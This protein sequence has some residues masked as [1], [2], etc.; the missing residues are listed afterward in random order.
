MDDAGA[1]K[2]PSVLTIDRAAFLLLRVKRAFKKKRQQ[3]KEKHAAAAA[4]AAADAL[5]SCRRAPPPLL[6]SRT[7]PA[8]VVPGL[9]ILHA[10]I[11]PARNDLTQSQMLCRGVS[12]H[13]VCGL[14]AQAPRISFTS[15]EEAE[16]HELRRKS[17]S[18]RLGSSPRSSI[19]SE[20]R[21]DGIVLRV[22]T[23]RG[24]VSSTGSSRLA[25]LLAHG[26]R[27]APEDVAMDAPR[28]LSWE[29]RESFG[30]LPRSASIDSMVEA[31]I[32]ARH[33]EPSQPITLQL[34]GRADRALS[35][36]SPAVGR[37]A[38]SQRGQ[39]ALFAAVEHGYLDKA[40]N[41]L[42]STDVDVNSLNP[43]G[44]SP[45]D[46]AV[47][48]NN[49]QLVRML[50]EFGAKEGTQFKSSEAL[51]AHLRR[52][53]REAEARLHEVA[54]CFP[55]RACRDEACTRSSA[56][57]QAGTTGCAGGAGSEK[58]KQAQHWERRVR[59]LKRLV[60]GWQQA[61]APP[62]PPPPDLEVCG[63]H[64]VTVRLRDHK[65]PLRDP[66]LVTKY[67]VEW[68]SRADFSNVCGTR[69]VALSASGTRVMAAGLTRGR[70]YFFRAA[71]GNV[72]GWGGFTVS[73]PRSVV[74]SSWRDVSTR[75]SRG[76][77]GGA[78]AA[79]EALATAAAGARQ[80]AARATAAT[81]AQED[82]YHSP[83]VHCG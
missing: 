13:K 74:P 11:D 56:G 14:R 18:S 55:E 4:A 32:C 77:S 36:V 39:A 57:G 40:R 66:P 42:E 81:A 53:T 83:A 68:S 10:Q 61:R 5:G 48:A 7:L 30:Q 54:G 70:R 80:T 44:L 69:E 79:L 46:V 50:M 60:H 38:K 1:A 25:R 51:G 41:I 29:R 49:R 21:A 22:P 67:K 3:R 12:T 33:S 75:A 58:D 63:A 28:R 35:L 71:A 23:P 24:S 34:P 19:A 26:G 62:P 43:D 6:R 17:A 65:P 82:R 52:L 27:G 73:T 45:L 72:K 20:E 8:I 9:S 59:T 31:A 76:D 2:R 15:K 37:R 47:L 64:A 78:A 16:T